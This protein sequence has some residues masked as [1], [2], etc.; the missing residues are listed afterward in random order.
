[1]DSSDKTGKKMVDGT[2]Q[3]SLDYLHF[4]LQ[5]PPVWL[6]RREMHQENEIT[7]DYSVCQKKTMSVVDVPK[8]NI[9]L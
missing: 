1:M 4:H 6:A 2:S 7:G 5:W 3:N 9:F 8:S